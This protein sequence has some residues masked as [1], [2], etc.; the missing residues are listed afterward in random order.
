M[1]IHADTR[2]YAHIHAYTRIYTHIQAYTRTYTHMHAYTRIYMHI[3]AYTHTKTHLGIQ[4]INI[5]IPIGSVRSPHARA[6]PLFLHTPHTPLHPV[7][8]LRS[9][10]STRGRRH[11]HLYVAPFRLNSDVG[12]AHKIQ[13]AH[14]RHQGR[15]KGN[16]K[17]P[18]H[19]E[20]LL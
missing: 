12:G 15:H 9:C 7:Y 16:W 4:C 14:G 17:N 19:S 5:S 6:P 1:N 20:A 10:F 8:R 11:H 2:R 18:K 3:R 13:G